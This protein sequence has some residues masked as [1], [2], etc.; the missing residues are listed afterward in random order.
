MMRNRRSFCRLPN[1]HLELMSAISP[2]VSSGITIRSVSEVL[3]RR[4]LSS[5][6]SIRNVC[7]FRKH[8]LKAYTR[9]PEASL[10]GW[11]L[12][13]NALSFHKY[14][15]LNSRTSIVKVKGCVAKSFPVLAWAW[16]WRS[17]HGGFSH[18][19]SLAAAILMILYLRSALLSKS[20]LFP[21]YLP[22]QSRYRSCKPCCNDAPKTFLRSG[23][24]T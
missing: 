15:S 11:A 17:R 7:G 20:K 2:I 16:L 24:Q 13:W 4:L 1:G 23:F 22:V 21:C 3:T 5:I 18:F 6:I 10:K 19:L 14:G 12:P 9:L 8:L